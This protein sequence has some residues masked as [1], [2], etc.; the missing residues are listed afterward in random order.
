MLKI[1]VSYTKWIFIFLIKSS[2]QLMTLLTLSFF[3]QI[4]QPAFVLTSEFANGISQ[5]SSSNP[6]SPLIVV[7]KVMHIIL[8]IRVELLSLSF[9]I[10]QL[11]EQERRYKSSIQGTRVF[12]SIDIICKQVGSLSAE[13][14]KSKSNICEL[15]TVMLHAKGRQYH[16]KLVYYIFPQVVNNLV[17]A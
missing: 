15:Q 7:N 16:L 9:I 14:H 13:L 10:W 11:N 5:R 2:S 12:H 8:K 17:A 4:T 6:Y 1:N 3:A